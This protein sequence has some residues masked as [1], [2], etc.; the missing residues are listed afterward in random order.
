MPIVAEPIAPRFTHALHVH[1]V[2]FVV[3]AGV[4]LR[5]ADALLRN[6]KDLVI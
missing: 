6:R 2:L 4:L 5:Y 1:V 3:L